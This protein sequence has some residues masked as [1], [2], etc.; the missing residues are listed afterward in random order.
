MTATNLGPRRF[1]GFTGRARRAVR[2]ILDHTTLG[3]ELAGHVTDDGAVLT[4]AANADD[5]QRLSGGERVIFDAVATLTV[6]AIE[7]A[8]CV[9]VDSRQVVHDALAVLWGLEGPA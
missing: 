2:L 1:T 3:A 4:V 6:P 8:A 9:D 7:V 5:W